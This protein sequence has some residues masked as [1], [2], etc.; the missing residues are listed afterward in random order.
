MLLEQQFLLLVLELEV[1]DHEFDLLNEIIMACG[2]CCVW[3]FN[4]L[5]YDGK[6]LR[7][8]HLKKG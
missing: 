5:P 6:D 2:V 3:L 8:L 4:V 1:G 7:A